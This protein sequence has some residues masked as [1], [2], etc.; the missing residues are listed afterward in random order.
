MRF[1]LTK[2]TS[3]PCYE[4]LGLS[5]NVEQT[6]QTIELAYKRLKEV[7]SCETNNDLDTAY[8]TLCDPKS[9]SVYVFNR[10][11]FAESEW[12]WIDH[13]DENGAWRSL[14]RKTKS[15]RKNEW[16]SS[17][18]KGRRDI[19]KQKFNDRKGNRDKRRGAY[20]YDD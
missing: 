3:L 16:A 10:E 1:Y 13:L 2:M 14:V 9:R 11:P 6:A 7:F 4:I 8:E 18:D 20:G 15:G 12:T 19:K 17:D 5:L